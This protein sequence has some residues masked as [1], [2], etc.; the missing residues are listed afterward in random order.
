MTDLV[1][2]SFSWSDIPAITA[3]YRHYVENSAITFDLEAPDEAA[4]AEKIARLKQLGHPL[5]VSERHNKLL[6]YAYAS[7]YRPRA[8]YRFTCEDSIYLDPGATGKGLGKLMLGELLLQS[9]AAGF[10][11]MLAV[12]TAGTDNSLRLHEN[13]GFQQVGYFRDVGFKFDRWHD[14]VHLQKTL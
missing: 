6:G 9:R 5:I 7:F 13:F 12:I 1:L 11:Q 8:A 3:L 10:R 4:M 2:R 14:V